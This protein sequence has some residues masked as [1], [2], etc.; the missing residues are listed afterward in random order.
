MLLYLW[1]AMLVLFVAGIILPSVNAMEQALVDSTGFLLPGLLASLVFAGL[2]GAA[3]IFL[4]ETTL[5]GYAGI[6]LG[7][8]GVGLGV[9]AITVSAAILLARSF[10]A[11]IGSAVGGILVAVV[12]L[13]AVLGSV[14]LL[15]G[16]RHL[17]GTLLGAPRT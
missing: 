3:S 12:A 13:N 6:V 4:P 16:Y 1:S 10:A 2:M 8:L 14:L 15:Q 7:F 9:V 5:P 17:Q 11:A